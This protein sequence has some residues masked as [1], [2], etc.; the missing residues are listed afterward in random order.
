MS[1]SISLHLGLLGEPVISHFNV[2]SYNRNLILNVACHV[3]GTLSDLL[4][5][6]TFRSLLPSGT[7]I[8]HCRFFQSD[9][10]G[11]SDLGIC[12]DLQTVLTDMNGYWFVCSHSFDEQNQYCSGAPLPSAPPDT[13]FDSGPVEQLQYGGANGGNAASEGAHSY[14]GPSAPPVSEHYDLN[15]AP[16][17]PPPSSFS[18]APGAPSPPP[19]LSSEAL[20]NHQVQSSIR[21]PITLE[22]FVDPVIASDGHTYERS[23]I[24]QLFSMDRSFRISP[25]TRAPFTNFNLI[26]NYSMR[27]LVR[28][29]GYVPDRAEVE[30]GDFSMGS[31]H[32]YVDLAA[33]EM[34][35]PLLARDR[36]RNNAPRG[37]GLAH[38][39]DTAPFPIR[40][41]EKTSSICCNYAL[42]ILIF[43]ILACSFND[44]LTSQLR[45]LT[46]FQVWQD[47]FY[48]DQL[49][50][51]FYLCT[52]I[53]SGAFCAVVLSCPSYYFPGFC[54]ANERFRKGL[55]LLVALL[56]PLGAIANF[57]IPVPVRS[58]ASSFYF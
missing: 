20:L 58:R 53:C 7:D 26:P 28:D 16:Q 18:V 37:Q 42:F 35:E 55:V 39:I 57:G 9:E 19:P 41:Q 33:N 15:D 47:K 12:I 34:E 56:F 31:F 1:I 54:C 3:Q 49:P 32:N 14:A 5:L 45:S 11:S 4:S 30:S 50:V 48:P 22:P 27:S 23:A 10:S 6:H 38:Q 13:E 36:A 52:A 21:C 17:P 8:V 51:C 24:M 44:T 25:L 46:F 43:C 2:F 29:A 40:L